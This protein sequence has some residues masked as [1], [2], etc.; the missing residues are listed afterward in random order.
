MF[1]N[2]HPIEQAKSNYMLE[3]AVL[4]LEDIPTDK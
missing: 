4:A 1:V 3:N 2:V